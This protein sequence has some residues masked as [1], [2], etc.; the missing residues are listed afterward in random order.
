MEEEKKREQK[1]PREGRERKVFIRSGGEGRLQVNIGT[2]SW[3]GQP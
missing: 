3:D 1:R 2:D